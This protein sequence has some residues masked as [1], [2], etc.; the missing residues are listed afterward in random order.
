MNKITL[1]LLIGV[2]VLMVLLNDS[3]LAQVIPKPPED[4]LPAAEKLLA[5][6]FDNCSESLREN[7]P[8]FHKLDILSDFRLGEPFPLYKLHIDKVYAIEDMDDFKEALEFLVWKVPIYLGSVETEPRTYFGTKIND[9]G[10]WRLAGMGGDPQHMCRAREA[11]PIEAGYRHAKIN[12]NT[13]NISLIL[14]EKDGNLQFLYFD[15]TG[16]NRIFEL[17]R[18]EDGSWPIFSRD[19][20]VDLVKRGKIRHVQRRG[21]D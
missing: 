9:G 13:S 11:Y 2:V 1:Y 4:M 3:L 21:L 16:G 20:L 5:T 7:L 15:D 12:F 19:Y 17:T 10:E 6:E 18:N 14:L 8:Y